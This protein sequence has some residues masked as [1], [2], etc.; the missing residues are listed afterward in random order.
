MLDTAK[1]DGLIP[2][3]LSDIQTWFAKQITS[4]IT[5][6]DAAD[7]PLFP[8][9]LIDEIRKRIA[10][11]PQMSSEERLGVYQQQYWWRIITICQEIFPTLVRLFGYEDFNNLIAKP[12]LLQYPP[13]DWFLSNIGS[14]LPKWLKKNYRHSDKTLVSGL[15]ALDL[16]Y[17]QLLFTELLLS[18]EPHV[19]AECEKKQ[20][21]LQPHVLLFALDGD[22]FGFRSQLMEHPPLHWETSDFP[23]ISSSEGKK[24]FVLYRFQEKSCYEEISSQ[25]YDLLACF[26]KGTRLTDLIPLLEQ[27]EGILESFQLMAARGWLSLTNPKKIKSG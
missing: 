6:S 9:D 26:K 4:P 23:Q 21:F 11:G 27:F 25:F 2:E 20:L 17:E 3:S 5:E 18:I 22:L 13:H 10:P 15:A 19:L 12:Y 7:I 14:D 24:Y 8:A 16:A 1:I